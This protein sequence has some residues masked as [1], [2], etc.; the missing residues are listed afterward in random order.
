MES[1]AVMQRFFFLPSP[2]L[3]HNNNN[4]VC[5]LE[6]YLNLLLFVVVVVVRN[7][8][9]LTFFYHLEN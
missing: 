1:L 5:D 7:G 9:G 4:Y 3:G 2:L 6:V 8:K